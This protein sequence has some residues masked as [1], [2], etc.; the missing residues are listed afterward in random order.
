MPI[1]Q[2]NICAQRS[3]KQRGADL[4]KVE[5]PRVEH[6]RVASRNVAV[7]ESQVQRFAS[8]TAGDTQSL[9]L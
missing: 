7:E 4:V 6:P 5:Q 9:L 2:H 3:L 1:D 8:H